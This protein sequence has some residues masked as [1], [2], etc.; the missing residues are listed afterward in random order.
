MQIFGTI[1]LIIFI[2]PFISHISTVRKWY[3]IKNIIQK[4]ERNISEDM[5]RKLIETVRK[6]KIPNTPEAWNMLRAGFTLINNSEEVSTEL[7]KQLMNVLLSKGVNLGNV[8]IKKS[9]MDI[10]LEKL[11]TGQRGEEKIQH[12]L[13]FLTMEGYKVLH[14]VKIPN[15]VYTQEID[16]IVIGPNGVFHIETKNFDGYGKI[17]IDSS[18]NWIREYDNSQ[19]SM[20]NPLDQIERHDIVIKNYLANEFPDRNIP[21][22]PILVLASEDYILEGQE[23]FPIDVIKGEQII[24]FIKNYKT[25]VRLEPQTIERIYQKL[26]RHIKESENNLVS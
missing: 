24:Y 16:H 15:K 1:L 22:K 14:N 10:E 5:V 2:L 18:G 21:V 26:S 9:K 6:Y 19:Y 7:K 3:R 23:N 25:N 12:S 11:E 8:R 20:R 4:F 17:I 13:D